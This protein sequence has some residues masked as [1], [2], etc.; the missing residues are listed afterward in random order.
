M[1]SRV[2]RE[3]WV[4]F[5]LVNKAN[6]HVF[7]IAKV[8]CQKKCLLKHDTERCCSGIGPKEQKKTYFASFYKTSSCMFLSINGCQT[9]IFGFILI[10]NTGHVQGCFR[11]EKLFVVLLWKKSIR[12]YCCCLQ[13]R[14]I[15]FIFSVYF[16]SS[17]HRISIKL[18][19]KL[20]SFLYFPLSS[21][22]MHK[23]Q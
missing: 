1:S 11:T 5:Y 22:S 12:V 3:K 23:A 15:S 2:T 9:N 8:D 20:T 13:L 6:S 19:V 10:A 21:S 4:S 7:P 18:T 14:G 16:F 17:V